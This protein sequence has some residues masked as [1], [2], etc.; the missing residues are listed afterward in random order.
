[1]NGDQQ[2]PGAHATPPAGQ[3]QFKP[4]NTP[5][6]AA[7]GPALQPP[8]PTSGAVEWTASEFIA[9]SKGTSW[10]LAFIAI[11]AVIVVGVYFVT[12][13]IISTIVVAVFGVIFGVVAAR[14]PRIMNYRLTNAGVN[15]GQRYYPFNEF[16]AFSVIDEGAFSSIVFWPMQRFKPSIG[17][18]YAPADEDKIVD[19]IAT[20]LPLELHQLDAIERFMRRIRF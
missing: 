10:Y 13:D 17:L 11:A 16:R 1:M 8:Q 6:A 12:R 2:Q 14:P 19:V 18:Y 7:T 15:I 20:Q 5:K 9:H 3:W 4:E